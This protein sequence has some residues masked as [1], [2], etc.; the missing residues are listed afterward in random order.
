MLYASFENTIVYFSRGQ[1][2]DEHCTRH[3]T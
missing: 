1:V 3:E 2:E